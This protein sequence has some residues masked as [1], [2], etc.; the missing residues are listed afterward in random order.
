MMFVTAVLAMTLAGS[1]GAPTLDSLT[2][3]DDRAWPAP[4]SPVADAALALLAAGIPVA[5]G[6][7]LLR[8]IRATYNPVVRTAEMDI[9]RPVMEAELL[10]LD[11][12]GAEK[13]SECSSASRLART[14]S[15][16][17]NSRLPSTTKAWAPCSVRNRWTSGERAAEAAGSGLDAP[18]VIAGFNP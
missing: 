6:G 3:G 10:V 16:I 4:G 17:S 5:L 8:L 11:D 1:G 15:S 7:G 18:C 14:C 13:P 9:L 2:A 12:L